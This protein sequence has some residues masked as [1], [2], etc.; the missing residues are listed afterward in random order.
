MIKR[1][2]FKKGFTCTTKFGVSLQSKRGFTLAEMLVCLAIV[3]TIMA[4]V[5]FN[6]STFND[7]LAINSAAQEVAASMRLAQSYGLSVK[8]ATNGANNCSDGGSSCHAYGIVF[9]TSGVQNNYYLFIDNNDNG[10]FD[11]GAGCGNS[12]SEC[13]EKY[14]LRNNIVM[15]GVCNESACPPAYGLSSVHITFLRPSTDA[16]V[17]FTDSNNVK[18]VVVN[19]SGKVILTSPK[20]KTVKVSMDLTGKIL[21]Q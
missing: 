11:I 5:L 6:F 18:T 17:A 21:I 8:Q 10:L 12:T 16:R 13:I 2:N 14:T 4:T 20:L 7:N 19:T 1:F 3:S 9:I 15:T